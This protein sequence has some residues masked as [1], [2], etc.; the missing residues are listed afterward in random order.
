MCPPIE[1]CCDLF[2]FFNYVSW[3]FV[4]DGRLFEMWYHSLCLVCWEFVVFF[5]YCWPL[6]ALWG[7]W[8]VTDWRHWAL[9]M[10]YLSLRNAIV[11]ITMPIITMIDVAIEIICFIG[12]TLRDRVAWFVNRVAVID[13][14]TTVNDS[15]V[16]SSETRRAG[17]CW[18]IIV[19]K[20]LLPIL[21]RILVGSCDNSISTINAVLAASQ[22][23][24]TIL[25]S[26]STGDCRAGSKN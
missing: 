9:S 6:D 1:M 20:V 19:H 13:G 11:P 8:F 2:F 3:L 4:R 25:R 24:Q 17:I 21:W 15:Y 14:F 26:I 7:Q 5:E 22:M 23:C 10:E 16:G 18:V 12:G